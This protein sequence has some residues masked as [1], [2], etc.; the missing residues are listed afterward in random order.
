M[1]DVSMTD[2]HT[3]TQPSPPSPGGPSRR[4]VVGWVLAAPTLLVAARIGL[5]GAHARPAAAA[6][7]ATRTGALAPPLPKVPQF[8]DAY[9]TQ[10]FFTVAFAPTN[11]L[12]TVSID[13][14]GTAH[15]ALPRAEVGQGITTTTAMIVAEE[16]D[17]PLSRVKVTLADARPEL[18]FNQWTGASSSTHTLYKP[19]RTAAATA[20]AQLKQAAARTWGL[21][22][23]ELRTAD[24][25]VLAP[26]GRRL[27]YAELTTAAASVTARAVRVELKDPS[28]FTTIGRAQR[29][30]DALAAVTGRKV[31]AMD[32]KVPGALPTMVCRPP[33][34][35]GTVQSV[36]NTAAVK[37]MPG[38]VDVAVIST[39]VAVCAHTFG[40]CIDAVRALRVDWG[41]GTIDGWDN[42]K[43]AK[44]L[45]AAERPLPPAT[46][47][48]DV[49]DE[50]FLFHFRGGSAL[51]TNCAVADVRPEAADVWSGLQTPIVVA[52]EVAKRF[53]LPLDKV[54]VHVVEAGGSF[55]RKF[56]FDAA[57]EAAEASAAFQ[58]PV[59][60]MWHR[61]DDI[62]HGRV[63]PMARS[64]VRISVAEGRVTAYEQQHTAVAT[65]PSPALGEMYS[66]SVMSQ[67]PLRVFE[68]IFQMW[69]TVPYNYG[70][71]TQFLGEIY[72]YDTFA[73]STVRNVWTPDVVTARELM[74]DQIAAK[75]GADPVDYRR[76][77]IIEDR[78]RA[79]LDA[80]AQAGR[81]GRKMAANTAQ[82]IAVH[83]EYKSYVACLVELD[84]RPATV[85]RKVRDAYTGP[86]VTKVVIALD[87]GL[88]INPRGLQA[89]MMGGAMDG[90]AQ[91]LT[92]GVHFRDGLPLEGSWD[93]YRYTRQWNTPFEVEVLV[94]P[95]TG[96]VPGGAGEFGVGVTQAAVAC[97]WARA[98]GTMPTE[99]PLNANAPLGFTPKPTVPPIPPAP[100]DGLRHRR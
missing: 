33:T 47:G 1:D 59:R 79:V 84:N 69:T 31:Y 36:A 89:Q 73:S 52:Q 15:L 87:V 58:R 23:H 86:R 49:L 88:P 100:T 37:R 97:A 68:G 85:H 76:H 14:E 63:H 91:A 62:R 18:L 82:G 96:E 65:D 16:L 60:L 20:R 98:T 61:T 29:R 7:Q 70:Q 6:P 25:A 55:G 92:A 99:F 46:P 9:E 54:K 34:L 28:T 74:T 26:D 32:L 22:A 45:A 64:R 5:D 21:D 39:G 90:I 40:Q 94:L 75:L 93:D 42:A 77:V 48:V 4:S 81:W 17:L 53:G 8:Y 27:D 19:L 41:P 44:D 30:I 95:A 51:E 24:G 67:R 13:R 71:A 3:S 35:K 72:E 10:Q 56:Y 83:T 80:C 50:T 38:V 11:H 66:A 12:I 2:P 57:L 43:V 78:L